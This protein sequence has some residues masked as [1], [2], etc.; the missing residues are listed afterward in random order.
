MGEFS[1]VDAMSP[2][3]PSLVSLYLPMRFFP[4][5]P[6]CLAVRFLPY[7][8][9]PYL[10]FP[11]LTLRHVT[12]RCVTLRYVTLRYVTSTCLTLPYVLLRTGALILSRLS[13]F[14]TLPITKHLTLPNLAMRYL[15]PTC[16]RN[17]LQYLT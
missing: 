14:R 11:Y 5:V 6:L 4:L 13:L 2:R 15:T 1:R 17:L 8:T 12:L 16:V 10:T 7:F 9:L 3:L